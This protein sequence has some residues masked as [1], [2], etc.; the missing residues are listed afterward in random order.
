MNYS[1]LTR[2]PVCLNLTLK[3][4]HYM[5]PSLSKLTFVL[6]PLYTLFSKHQNYYLFPNRPL[7]LYLLNCSRLL[8]SCPECLS[9]SWASFSP[10]STSITSM[11]PSMIPSARYNHTLSYG[12]RRFYLCFSSRS[13][14]FSSCNTFFSQITEKIHI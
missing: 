12:P 8:F 13:D 6:P 7:L 1:H 14:Y 2:S 9:N 3:L 5:A 10:G 4:F 11:K